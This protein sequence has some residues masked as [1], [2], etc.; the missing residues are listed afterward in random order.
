MNN[1]TIGEVKARCT[2]LTGKYGDK[3]CDHC[4]FDELGCCDSPDNWKVDPCED[5]PDWE[6][7]FHS[8]EEKCRRL[9][10]ENQHL[11][12]IIGAVETVLGREF[13]AHEG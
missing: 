7:M 11:R 9:Y 3:C 13:K 2:E 1:V 10:E 4:E 6:G 8:A 12:V 5:H